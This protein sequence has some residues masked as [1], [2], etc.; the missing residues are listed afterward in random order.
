MISTYAKLA[1]AAVLLA[2]FA[3]GAIA[4]YSA[5]KKAGEDFIQAAWDKDKES[6]A[7]LASDEAAKNAKKLQDAITDNEGIVNDLQ[8]QIDAQRK[9]N[10]DLASRLR[11]ATS[12]PAGSSS[13]PKAPNNSIPSTIT[14]NDRL[15]QIDDAIAAVLT[16]CAQTRSDY[17]ALIAEIKPQI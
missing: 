6:I 15:G 4:D 13:L 16:E 3:W 11:L 14:V 7:K 12:I 10:S 5:G 2:M 17:K 8:N 9:L 1:G